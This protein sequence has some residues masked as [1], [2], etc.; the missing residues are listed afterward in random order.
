YQYEINYKSNLWYVNFWKKLSQ[1]YYLDIFNLNYDNI[2]NEIIP[3]SDDGYENSIPAKFDPK[4]LYLSKKHR[5][6]NL[7]GSIKLFNPD[8]KTYNKYFLQLNTDDLWKHDS[9]SNAKQ[10]STYS[11]RHTQTGDQIARSPIIVGL[12]KTDKLI[13]YPFSEYNTFFHNS[14]FKNSK[15]LIIGYSFGDLYLNALLEKFNYIHSN[16]RKIAIVDYLPTYIR[17]NNSIKAMRWPND[18]MLSVIF[19]MFN[20]QDPFKKH[21]IQPDFLTSNDERASLY[22]K[23]FQNSISENWIFEKL[24]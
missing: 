12:R 1:K 9:Y 23:G 21:Y 22:L 10:E 7:H 15:L 19:R 3:E 4:L 11:N 20:E 6:C 14:I 16:K 8:P 24:K 2:L 5:I 18:N 17:W 13:S